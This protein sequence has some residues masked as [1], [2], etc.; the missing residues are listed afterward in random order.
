MLDWMMSH[1]GTIL[2]CGVLAAVVAVAIVSVLRDRK[3]G[4][5][6]CGGCCAHCA[7]N[8]HSHKN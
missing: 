5:S 3:R 8:C 1:I 2:V 7:M 4:K 6:A